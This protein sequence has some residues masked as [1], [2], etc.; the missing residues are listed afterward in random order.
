MKHLD[1]GFRLNVDTRTLSS[2]TCRIAA[3]SGCSEISFGIESGSDRILSLMN[4]RTTAKENVRFVK[5]VQSEGILTKAYFI[6]NFPG[7]TESSVRETLQWAEE[8]RPDK[9]LLSAFAP[10]PGS[11]TFVS[12]EQ[13]GIYWMSNNWED[14]YLVGKG[15]SFR[16]CFRSEGLGFDQQIHLHDLMRE[17]LTTILGKC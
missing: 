6:V 8:A 15:G 11:P 9:W 17:G 5:R 1:I 12:P 7:E 3:E 2:E 4:K 14:Y 16:P 10:L 13:F